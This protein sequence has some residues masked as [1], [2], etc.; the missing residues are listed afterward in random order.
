METKTIS[1]RA[2][3]RRQ[4]L[5]VLPIIILPFI[6]LLF[7]ILGGGRMEAA[8]AANEI[9][10]GFNFTLPIPKFK[11]DS[12]LD[13]MS[14]YD[15]AAVDSLK[16]Q[17]Q[18]KKDPNYLNQKILEESLN[19]FTK[20]DFSTQGFSKNRTGLNS[21]PLQ[22]SNEQK[23]Y[24]KLQALQKAVSQPAVLDK[25]GHDMREFENYGSSKGVTDEIQHL[26]KMMSV[27]GESTGPDPEMAQL[28][29]MLENILDIQHPSRVQERLKQSSESKKGKT[30]AVNHKKAENNISYLEQGPVSTAVKPNSFY[31]I[32]QDTDSQQQNSTQAVIHE[33]QTIVNGSIVKLRLHNDVTLQGNVIPKN[34]FLYGT[35]ALKGERLEV[36]I[37]NIQYRNSIFPIQLSVYDIDG[38]EGIYVPG[39]INRDSAKA[40]ADRSIQTL[41]LT[42]ITD[43][44]GAQAAGMGIEAAKSLMSKK[45]KLVKVLVKAGYQVLL[46]DEKQKN[47]N[48]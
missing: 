17:E 34:T 44:W 6:T 16:L 37:D 15:Q 35:A 30:Y 8:E 36:K 40:S 14:Y 23:I 43:S 46:Y 5:L 10:K 13:K 47:F 33:T 25:Y 32:E 12:T 41:G 39:T 29:G 21:K 42:G 31:T 24:E 38:I 1:L 7:Y 27:M 3:K 45:V 48:Q 2:S 28:G 19:D 18:I 22:D 9:K 26:E 20:S 11:E 4:M